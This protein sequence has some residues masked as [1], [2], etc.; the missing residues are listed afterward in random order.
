MRWFQANNWL[1]LRSCPV[2]DIMSATDSHYLIVFTCITSHTIAS[3]AQHCL[4]V[5]N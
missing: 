1:H 2:A 3:I 5:L 4:T